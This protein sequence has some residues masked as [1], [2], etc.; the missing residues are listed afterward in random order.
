MTDLGEAVHLMECNIKLNGLIEANLHSKDLLIESYTGCE[1]AWGT[2]VDVLKE[3]S[4]LKLFDSNSFQYD[5]IIASDIVYYPEGYEPLVNSIRDLLE[6][7]L[8]NS[9][10]ASPQ[11]SIHFYMAHRH[12]HPDDPKFFRLL[13][14]IPYIIVN[15][16]DWKPEIS[17]E[18]EITSMQ[19][20]RIFDIYI[21]L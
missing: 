6:M 18:N 3:N 20:I 8:N 9:L 15:E 17:T 19:D 1:L 13:S 12:R 10:S 7:S 11:T 14:E 4:K 21:Q 5:L 2:S 16:I